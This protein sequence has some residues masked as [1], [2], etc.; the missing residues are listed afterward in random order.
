[1]VLTRPVED[2][3]AVVFGYEISVKHLGEMI[4]S[5]TIAK[6]LSKFNIATSESEPQKY[7]FIARHEQGV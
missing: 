5:T 1:M 3:D 2:I 7:Q 4:L 6:I